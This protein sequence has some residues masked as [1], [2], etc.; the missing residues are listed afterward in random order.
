[1]KSFQT[2]LKKIKP[3]FTKLY[4]KRKIIEK[5]IIFLV[6]ACILILPFFVVRDVMLKME[7]QQYFFMGNFVEGFI[8]SN[9]GL[10]LSSFDNNVASAYA[11]QAIF[12]LVPLTIFIISP[13]RYLDIGASL[14]FFG[15]FCNLVDRM[16][17]DHFVYLSNASGIVINNAV[18]DYWRFG[19]VNNSFIFNYADVWVIFGVI[20]IGIS[21]LIMIIK[22]FK[23][24]EQNEKNKI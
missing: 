6:S 9:T 24:E 2:E 3:Y 19:F 14:M 15:G 8:I 11:L 5:V 21:L 12:S 18:V 10:G 4:T 1:M 13:S 23:E 16:T 17:P 20:I 22:A 7:N